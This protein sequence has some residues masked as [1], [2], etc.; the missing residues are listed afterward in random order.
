MADEPHPPAASSAILRQALAVVLSF[1]LESR[2][3]Q[4]GGCSRTQGPRQSVDDLGPVLE[5]THISIP[6][7]CW[8]R[9]PPV[10]TD[11]FLTKLDIDKITKLIDERYNVIPKVAIPK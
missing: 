8:H 3:H 11:L 9:L 7:L 4:R 10:Y 5:L 1:Y 6:W 2:G